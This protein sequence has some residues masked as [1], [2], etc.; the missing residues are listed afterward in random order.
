MIVFLRVLKEIK[1]KEKKIR[2][3]LSPI[4]WFLAGGLFKA[5][6]CQNKRE[7]NKRDM[8]KWNENAYMFFPQKSGLASGTYFREPNIKINQINMLLKRL[9]VFAVA[10]E[11]CQGILFGT[12][13]IW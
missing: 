8:P 4:L 13:H 1:K 12:R 2:K 5:L 7:M 9:Y 11:N 10:D 3:A 6:I